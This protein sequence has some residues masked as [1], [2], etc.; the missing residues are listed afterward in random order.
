MIGK[1]FLG[2]FAAIGVI[3]TLF[4]FVLNAFD[5]IRAIQ[6]WRKRRAWAKHNGRSSGKPRPEA[7]SLGEQESKVKNEVSLRSLQAAATDR[8]DDCYPECW[9]WEPGDWG[10]ALAGETGELCNKV[11]KRNA[12]QEISNSEM[13]EELADVVIYAALMASSLKLDLAS[14][15]AYKFNMRSKELGWSST[16]LWNE[17]G[18]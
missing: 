13:A 2:F 1:Y 3:V 9:H 12:G 10:L 17:E 8:H 4:S 14:S 16:E 15:V 11:K 6:A 5:A 18:K 7:A